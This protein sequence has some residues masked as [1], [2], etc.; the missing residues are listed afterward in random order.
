MQV[1]DLTYTILQKMP[2]INKCQ[3]LFIMRL[4]AL[5]LRMPSKKTYLMMARYGEYS[6]QTYRLQFSK[7]FDIRTFNRHLIQEHCG[8][9]KV[10]VF[11]PSYLPKSGK[12]T[13]GAGYFWSGGASSLRWGLEI[14]SLAIVDVQ[15]R[16]ALHYHACQTQAGCKE[17]G[18]KEAGCKE[19]GCKEAGCKEATL[20]QRYAS[21]ITEQAGELQ[22]LSNVLCVDA[23]F[24]KRPFIDAIL[25]RG[26]HVVSRLQKNSYLRYASTAE[27]SS[28][29]GRPRVYDGKVNVRSLDM[30]HCELIASSPQQAVYQAIVHVKSL[31]RWCKIVV[32]QTLKEGTITN[33][34]TYVATDTTMAGE[35]I[36]SYYGLRF[37]IEFL[38][39]D[40]KN[41]TGLH[42]CQSR[43][44]QAIE[45]H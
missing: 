21:Y 27:K 3:A 22:Q 18:C 44:P 2:T 1:Q 35:Q 15:Q 26:M 16:T 17:A 4:L 45:Y 24:S 9:E 29:R 33:V 41:F 6:E 43:T 10:W 7:E 13:P 39:R 32:L 11:D 30:R 5:F 20:L 12:K 23:Y 25:A 31:Q 42:H 14:G 37:Q 38:F 36:L 28:R 19:A 8:G 40:A 34:Q